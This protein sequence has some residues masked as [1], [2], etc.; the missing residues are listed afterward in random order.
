MANAIIRVNGVA[1]SA[2]EIALGSTVQLTNADTTNIV[3]QTWTI[4]DAPKDLFGNESANAPA[5]TTVVQTPAFTSYDFI[6]D[7]TGEWLILLQATDNL[8][9]VYQDLQ[10]VSVRELY[11]NCFIP[12]F[13][14]TTQ[15]FDRGWAEGLNDSFK[16][17]SR[18][19][20]SGARVSVVY[21]GVSTLFAGTAVKVV[22][23][24]DARTISP[25]SL[26][27]STLPEEFIYEVDLA[28]AADGYGIDSRSIFI[29]ESGVS[30]A[31]RFG[32]AVSN[33]FLRH[34]FDTSS[35][36]SVGDPVYI[37]DSGQL[38]STPGSETIVVGE[39]ARVDASTGF[40]TIKSGVN[41]E[42]SITSSFQDIYDNNSPPETI[43]LSASKGPFGIKDAATPTGNQ[44]F[45]I[46]KNNG[47]VSYISTYAGST[48]FG[49][50]NIGTNQYNGVSIY[51]ATAGASG[52]PQYSPF[53]SLLGQVW[54]SGASASRFF[55]FGEQVIL[56]DG[57]PPTGSLKW[58][59]SFNG[60]SYVPI[61]ELTSDG[62]LTTANYYIK[63]SNN[64][65]RFIGVNQSTSGTGADLYITSG[66]GS[67][68]NAGGDLFVIANA[69]GEGTGG[70]P[71]GDGGN[72]FIFGGAPGADNGG[73]LGTPG[74]I[75]IDVSPQGSPTG[76]IFLGFS[77]ASRVRIGSGT[78]SVEIPNI[79][80]NQTQQHTVPAVASG[81]FIVST[82][83]YAN[84]S[85]ITSLAGSKITGDISGNATSVTLQQAYTNGSSPEQILLTAA[86]GGVVIKDAATP[87]A[88][89]LFNVVKNDG[90][91]NYF[92]VT[93]GTITAE[94]QSITDYSS[95]NALLLRNITPATDE[96]RSQYSPMLSL[97][98][99]AWKT[100]LSGQTNF[101]EMSVQ[102]RPIQGNPV[103][104]EWVWWSSV[105]NGTATEVAKLSSLGVY[106][107]SHEDFNSTAIVP[108]I[109]LEDTAAAIS[110]ASGDSNNSP[111]I[112]FIGQSWSE[113]NMQSDLWSWAIRTRNFTNE[114]SD[115]DAAFT[116]SCDVPSN[117]GSYTAGE[118]DVIE[119][120]PNG[121]I[122]SYFAY[123]KY[124]TEA[125]TTAL[126]LDQTSSIVS[127]VAGSYNIALNAAGP[128]FYLSGNVGILAQTGSGVF[129]F[130]ASSGA[131]NTSVGQNT[132]KGLTVLAPPAS[133]SGS[134]N[135]FSITPPA[136]TAL[137]ASTESQDLKLDLART[138]QFS[139]GA[140]TTQRAV[141]V[142]AP[143]YAF[144]GASTLTNAAT[145][146][147][148]GAPVQ[149]ANATLTNKYALWVESGISTFSADSIGTAQTEGIR[150]L[151]S[152]AAANGAQQYSP[153][154]S[155]HGAGWG[156]TGGAS[157]SVETGWQLRPIQSTTA[158]VEQVMFRK[159]G[160]D[161]SLS[162]VLTIGEKNPSYGNLSG[163]T[164]LYLKGTTANYLIGATSLLV[165][166][167]AASPDYIQFASATVSIGTLNTDRVI[168]NAAA[169]RAATD[170]AMPLGTAS[171][172]WARFY[173]GGTTPVAGDFSLSAGWGN[174][175]TVGTI[176]GDDNHVQFI[177]SSSGT[178][179]AA[180]P[181]IT[182]TFKDGTWTNAPWA[183][184]T[185]EATTDGGVTAPWVT[186]TTTA[187]TLVIT[188][189]GTPVA[190]S[191]YTFRAM[192]IGG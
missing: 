191:T 66:M 65:E 60:E 97:K 110:S 40:V 103:S 141:R 81:E 178:G 22:D 56:T 2:D 101:M 189:H 72:I 117:S 128:Y 169:V 4:I 122:R 156:T 38:S 160:G 109:V 135:L 190:G 127:I 84:P 27:G 163:R 159:S 52:L 35:F 184:T 94:R 131:F 133:S 167:D 104:G 11:N 51:S 111:A 23:V 68:T 188:F 129:D 102:L 17:F 120:M 71:S 164:N 168:I 8:T 62:Y 172:R 77:Y 59:K 36:S 57:N 171:F 46:S 74:I 155:Y 43:V 13:S 80:P 114:D 82:G 187:T 24:V 64:G 15:Y 186:C 166:N 106:T 29:L 173:T 183:Q 112:Q 180:N 69:G 34:A 93:T 116:F 45:Y 89:S 19:I 115:S 85:W 48:I 39:V 137:T 31:D 7:V 26:T 75:N 146:A 151:N 21:N 139:T 50:E 16:K 63:E 126:I 105:N 41:K 157:Q 138:V 179:Q 153:Y 121:F 134:P 124:E 70:S 162:E 30:S 182:Y 3:S 100:F 76:T 49:S 96:D 92:N 176:T 55:E 175:A 161:G 119:I 88:A 118:R 42:L 123:A 58:F 150:L 147:I 192:C 144:V 83:S 18:F 91:V 67:I 113:A 130:S 32:V 107:R 181:T 54:D 79:G 148:S 44:L 98:G 87:I 1:G 185:L 108:K 78:N 158:L 154:I 149:G 28:T 140:L 10:T 86:K 12:A 5:G 47:S 145:F 33:G 152:T 6:P 125:G 90:S 99:N 136:H 25:H 20:G 73:G 14:R 142:T 9:N 95:T 170:K 177:V 143:T 165:Q 132:L 37:D 53:F 174:T 61:A